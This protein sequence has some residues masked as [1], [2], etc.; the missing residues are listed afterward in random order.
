M[1][2][3]GQYISVEHNG[4]AVASGMIRAVSEKKYV[5]FSLAEKASLTKSNN[6]V[7]CRVKTDMGSLGFTSKVLGVIAIDWDLK[8]GVIE[9]PQDFVSSSLRQDERVIVYLPVIVNAK[10]KKEASG[11]IS[12]FSRS[13]CGLIYDK[14]VV[15]GES[16]TISGTFPG[17]KEAT[18][19]DC[20]VRR[21]DRLGEMY[22]YGLEFRKF[23]TSQTE[24]IDTTLG[25][26]ERLDVFRE[27]T[28]NKKGLPDELD[29]GIPIQAEI[30]D[31]KY[32]SILRGFID[33]KFVISDLP[34]SGGAPMIIPQGL[35][36]IMGVRYLHEAIAYGF[37]TILFNSYA[38]PLP[39]CVWRYPQQIEQF[40]VRTSKRVRTAAISVLTT[41]MGRQAGPLVDLSDG[42]C[43]VV[44]GSSAGMAQESELTMKVKFSTGEWFDG[45]TCIVKSIREK[46]N[47]QLI[48]MAFS[49]EAPGVKKLQEYYNDSFYRFCSIHTPGQS[50]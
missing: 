12:D 28:R 2:N 47:S 13:G 26:L 25:H 43:M 4:H 9:Y 35:Q 5:L 39:V 31:K 48:S 19:F 14:T 50:F 6:E 24:I 10:G 45:V 32:T 11:V 34:S 38:H 27:A 8:L 33:D 7:V 42:G 41:A 15:V 46:S 29:F 3:I 21:C 36:V 30:G 37:R 1:L 18:S 16:L 49:Q 40:S 44:V 22:V 17:G 20:T 23:A